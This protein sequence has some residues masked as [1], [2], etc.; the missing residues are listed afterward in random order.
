[1]KNMI[2]CLSLLF[3]VVGCATT[4]NGAKWSCRAEGLADY[5]YNGAGRAYIHLQ[6]YSSGH[7]YK[8][9][10]NAQGTE[11]TGNTQDGTPFS[12]IKEK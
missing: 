4:G 5:R 11:A 8:V 7:D 3:A 6:S 9:M 10:L 12:C 1:M 2:L